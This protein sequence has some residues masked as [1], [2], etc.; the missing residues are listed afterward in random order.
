M[1]RVILLLIPVVL[2][3]QAPQ[4]VV[5]FSERVQNTNKLDG[6]LPLYYDAKQGKLLLEVARLNEEFLYVPSLVSGV[7]SNDI[8]L[9]RGQLGN[10]KVVRF[11]R[12]GN[13]VLLVQ[14]N[15]A[16]RALSTDNPDERR[17]IEDSFAKS[18]LY[19]FEILAEED[20]RVLLDATAFALRDAHGVV[21]ALRRTRQGEF[22]LDAARSVIT[23]ERTKAFPNNSEIEVLLT[24]ESTAPGNYVRDVVP[25]PESVSVRQ[26]HSFVKLPG[27]GYQPRAFN[28]N[29]GYFP[30]SVADYTSPFTERLQKRWITRHRLEKKDPNAAV[31]D[32][33]EPIVYYVDRGTPEPIRTALVEGARWWN[34]AFEAAG[35]RNAF[36]VEVMPEGM[37]AMDARYNVIQWVHRATRGWSY[38]ASVVDPRTG[39]IIKGHVTLGSLRARQD[40]LIA[41]GLLAP[42]ENSGQVPAELREFVLARIRQLSAHEVGHTL[43]LSH[44]Y[45]ASTRNRASVMDY[46]HP[47]VSLKNGKPALDGAYATGIGEAD[48]YAIRYGYTQFAAGTD[49]GAALRAILKE[50]YAKGFPF[51]TDQ[52]ARPIGSSH[53]EAHLWDNGADVGA[54]LTRMLEVRNVALQRFGEK[55]IRPGTPLTELEDVLV[56]LYLSHR[57]QTEATSKSIG[58]TTYTYAERGDGQVPIRLVP[59]DKQ[60]AALKAVLATLSPEVLGPIQRFDQMPAR[61]FGYGRTRESFDSMTGLNFDP[62][63]AAESAAALPLSLLLDPARANRLVQQS[64]QSGQVSMEEVLRETSAQIRTRTGWRGGLLPAIRDRIED[65]YV[66]ELMRLAQSDAASSGVRA[67]VLD[68]LVSL[69]K[70]SDAASDTAHNRYLRSRIEQFLKEPKTV[71]LPK[72]AEVPPGQ[73]IGCESEDFLLRNTH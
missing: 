17:S 8:G 35:Y 64:V 9:D 56:P 55:A 23:T 45:I 71:T 72:P 44:N 7:G 68:H 37:D 47:L 12:F 63:T 31:S 10:E 1:L 39:E 34:Q 19:A 57:Y 73:P 66:T 48:K 38:G 51:L 15:Y 21:G 3:A 46:P 52:D 6:F 22:R 29:S 32:A 2:L 62:V 24:F 69:S 25:T 60:R 65:R 26:R 50:Q 20:G 53:P 4:R 5:S 43:G 58:G 41:E 40:F 42:Y 16:Y 49:E 11:E 33:V 36:Q 61:A 14:P 27:S 54:E 30:T 70:S 67:V 13:K 28:P 59:A 18:V